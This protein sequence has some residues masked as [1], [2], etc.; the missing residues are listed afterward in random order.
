[1]AAGE[2]FSFAEFEIEAAKR[3]LLK[4][5][6]PVSLNPKAFDLLL[7][8]V[9]ARGTVL[10]KD[11]LL[12]MVWQ[13]QFVEE[14]NLTVHVAALR[15]ILGETK[16]E[17]RFI[18]T[19]PGK[20]YAFVAKVD[21]AQDAENLNQSIARLSREN[22]PAKADN[23]VLPQTEDLVGRESLVGREREIAEIK[24]MLRREG[25]RLVT[26]TGTG[27]TGKTRLA[28]STAEELSADFADGVFFIELAAA[29][30]PEL[31]A[32]TIAQAL[33][34]KE[35][36][37]KSLLETLKTFLG[38]RRM[39][40]ILDNFE[41][42]ISAAKLLTGL[43][44]SSSFLKILVTSRITLRLNIE[45]EFVV[46][47]LAVPPRESH[48]SAGELS[49]FSAIELFVLRAKSARASFILDDENA[50][51][52]A[53]ICHKLDGLPLAIELAAAR[54]RL[55]S[56]DS[57]LTRLE[58]ALKLL[59]GGAKHLPERH[60]TMR[61]AIEWSYY[62]LDGDEKAIFRR[63]AVF[64]GGFTVEA[65]EKVCE[66]SDQAEAKPKLEILDGIM[67]LFENNLLALREQPDGSAR[68]RMLEVVREFSLERLEASGEID[69]FRRNHAEFFLALAENAEPH[70]SAERA[71]EWLENLEIEIDN[72]RA[73][74]DWSLQN[75]PETA[76]RI[77][78]A[79][80]FFWINHSHLTEGREWLGST[81]KRSRGTHHS[82]RF[83]LLAGLGTMSRL[84]GDY[85]AAQKFYK[86]GFDE[87]K[88]NGDLR[89]ISL[90]A[91][92]LGTVAQLRNDYDDARKYYEEGVAVS[93]EANDD[94][95]RGVSL[96]CLADLEKSEGNLVTARD[97][98]CDALTIFRKLGNKE[99]VSSSLNNL[100]VIA[101]E[102]TDFDAAYAYFSE[103]LTIARELKHKINIIDSLNGFAALAA[104]C[105]DPERALQI[106]GAAENLRESIGYDT[107]P[108]ERR[109]RE[110]YLA[111]TRAALDA[112]AF[113][114]A[115]EKGRALLPDE[116]V[117]LATRRLSA[118]FEDNQFTEIVIENRSISR[119][120]V[121]DEIEEDKESGKIIDVSPAA[122]K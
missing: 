32:P 99:T 116:A 81:L 6:A 20:G 11:E 70:L 86:Q 54:V 78:A 45:H 44:D 9:R 59:K 3:L 63:L 2:I 43:L 103:G 95:A 64:A 12:E 53:E 105:G 71:G 110:D 80:R 19:I 10:S 35:S 65:A 50:H 48:F 5:G 109:F 56:V 68:L 79:S 17:H 121:E 118:D 1:M 87:G 97:L 74:L 8:L 14:N 83:K 39:L 28:K 94:F 26:L 29:S 40:L 27:G 89:Q 114:T 57:I 112:K 75:E 7:T 72:L 82:L 61:A 113:E 13:G 117:A 119:I 90:S 46:T 111:K 49:D 66:I 77:A 102:Q 24:N 100:G 84:Q 88:A 23:L 73:A 60:Q 101:F 41:Q 33:G 21:L 93:R 91:S 4:K 98:L 52:I 55:L 15:K 22:F 69:A 25:A 31:V 34:V 76:T 96:N 18:V 51:V 107:E 85:E 62:L 38:E 115:C 106:A 16:N 36:V 58:T 47:P 37:D 30:D 122:K 104:R 42:L 92:G 108:A 120:V 67:S